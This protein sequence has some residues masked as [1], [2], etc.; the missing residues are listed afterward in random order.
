MLPR[1]TGPD[2]W[3]GEIGASETDRLGYARPRMALLV[4]YKP[5]QNG[6]GIEGNTPVVTE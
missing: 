5:I 6:G 3:R 1:H 2:R 4:H